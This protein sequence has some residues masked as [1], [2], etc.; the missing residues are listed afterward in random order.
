MIDFNNIL[1]NEKC[2]YFN[3]DENGAYIRCISPF[4]IEET[5]IFLNKIKKVEP[6][7]WSINQERTIQKWFIRIISNDNIEYL[8]VIYFNS[9]Q[10]ANNFILDNIKLEK[11]SLN[12]KEKL[13]KIIEMLTEE[14][15]ILLNNICSKFQEN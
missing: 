9:F 6:L 12:I 11:N 7:F 2:N 5:L 4:R 13:F 8:S 3:F 10:E 14:E 1:E 15:L